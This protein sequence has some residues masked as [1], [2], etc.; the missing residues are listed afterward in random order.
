MKGVYDL[1]VY[2]PKCCNPIRGEAIVGYITRGKGVAVHAATCPN[3]ESLM[4][5]VERRIDVE[6]SRSTSADFSVKVI[7]YTD[8]RP[9]V[10]NSLTSILK[11]ENSNIQTLEAR[12]DENRG[13]DGAV[14]EMTIEVQDKRQ[15]QRLAAA[16]RR[17]SGVRDVERVQ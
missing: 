17:V 3:V 14:I 8:D 7:V 10:L 4:Y 12:L 15:F 9:G 1:M 13:G 6:W 2:R 16:M 5:E 11:N